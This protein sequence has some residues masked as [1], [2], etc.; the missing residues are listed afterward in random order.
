MTSVVK[1]NAADSQRCERYKNVK[2]VLHT[3]S[4]KVESQILI[5]NTNMKNLSNQ[6]LL[7]GVKN[8]Q[9]ARNQI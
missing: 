3:F 7:E 5:V 6:W 2:N 1:R 9:Q 8:L 4:I